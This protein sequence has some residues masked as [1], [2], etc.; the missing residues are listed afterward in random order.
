MVGV[1]DTRPKSDRGNVSLP[2]GAQAEDKTQRTG[3]KVGLVSMRHDGGIEQ[4]C[5][6]QREF[7]NEIGTNQQLS[8]F[9][10]FHIGQHEVS[11]LFEPFQKGSVDLLVS[12]GEFSGYFVQEWP[13][14]A[15]RE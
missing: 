5:R 14:L 3:R 13:D 12:L 8:L 9:G 2:G 4:G 10:N 7:T 1:D 11:D 15:F 6:L